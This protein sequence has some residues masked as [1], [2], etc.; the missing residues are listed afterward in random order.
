MS[1]TVPLV[2]GAAR[3][4]LDSAVIISGDGDPVP[5]IQSARRLRPDLRFVVL[6]PPKRVRDAL[7]QEAD[8]SFV[9]R[10]RTGHRQPVPSVV[11]NQRADLQRP[12]QGQ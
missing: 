3:D 5:A 12:Q 8:A 2:E 10:P 7:R 4:D 9:P 1:L 11:V 6:F